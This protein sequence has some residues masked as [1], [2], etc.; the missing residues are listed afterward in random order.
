MTSKP[1]DVKNGLLMLSIITALR[2]RPLE[3][4][5][6]YSACIYQCI[7]NDWAKYLEIKKTYDHDSH[8]AD[9]TVHYRL[10]PELE[11]CRGPEIRKIGDFNRMVTFLDEE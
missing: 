4:N 6:T 9:S 5:I 8:E 11:S 7:E 2:M 1:Q 10:L 3:E